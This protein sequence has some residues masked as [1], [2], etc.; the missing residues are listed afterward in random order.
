MT[1]EQRRDR[2]LGRCILI[3]FFW[4]GLHLYVAYRN[5]RDSLYV[6]FN[7]WTFFW[8]AVY[9]FT[10]LAL[11]VQL[12]FLNS[13][14]AAKNWV[15][16]WIFCT[17]VC[18]LTLLCSYFKVQIGLWAVF[19]MAATP[20]VHWIPLWDVMFSRN[21]ILGNGCTLLLCT[22]HLIYFLWLMHRR[23]KEEIHGD[24]DL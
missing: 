21:S 20:L 23:N 2:M 3:G 9:T 16:Y 19:P 6:T 8:I 10:L 13:F 1:E 4:L 7:G 18:I 12:Y 15:R 17:V 14:N 24:V 11:D 22:A 5:F